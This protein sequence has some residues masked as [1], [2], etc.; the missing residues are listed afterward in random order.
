MIDV[1]INELPDEISNATKPPIKYLLIGEISSGKIITQFSSLS[2]SKKIKKEI[3]QIFKKLSGKKSQKHNERNKISSKGENYYFMITDPDYLN[4]ILADDKYPEKLIFQLIEK[5]NEEKILLMVNEET[6]EL[7]ASGRLELKKLVDLYQKETNFSD[8]EI[9]DSTKEEE[10]FN[11]GLII[12]TNNNDN[13]NE[14]NMEEMRDIGNN[15]NEVFQNL[16]DKEKKNSN[17]I[18]NLNW[19]QNYKIWIILAVII[20]IILAIIIIIF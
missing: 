3:N 8:A 17:I 15:K 19:W 20:L 11:G 18:M 7:N 14:D 2:E 12:T 5:I 13:K 1:K 6:L 4:I 10:N 16:N 9:L